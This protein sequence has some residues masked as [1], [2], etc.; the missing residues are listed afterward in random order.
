MPKK[1]KEVKKEK[2]R[3]RTIKIRLLPRRFDLLISR[4]GTRFKRLAEL[5]AKAEEAKFSRLGLIR[6]IITEEKMRILREI[7]EHPPSSIYE[8]AKRLGRDIKT[9]RQDIKQ[10]VEIGFLSLER[11]KAKGKVEK[12]KPVLAV[13]SLTIVIDLA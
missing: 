11:T 2:K 12:A 5:E 1:E 13:D 4:F 10:L 7:K 6:S 9:V 3:D 8:L